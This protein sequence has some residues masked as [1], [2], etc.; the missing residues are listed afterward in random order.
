MRIFD[1]IIV[2]FWLIFL[3]YWLISSIG[4]KSNQQG[5][6]TSWLREAGVRLAIA[7]TIIL[8]V[9]SPLRR[10]MTSINNSTID[11]IGVS[12]CGVGIACAIWARV[13][14][15][16]NWGMPATLKME[17]ELVSNGPYALV[18]HPIYAGI[19]MAIVGTALV[20]GMSGFVV[21]VVLCT[22]FL[23][24]ATK[25]EKF[26][27]KEFPGRYADYKHR[28]KMLIPFVL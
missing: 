22:Y 6:G 15:G 24:S 9:K 20:A 26:M 3:V 5:T 16:R 28:T 11:S 13:Y 14:L 7:I 23:H 1:T 10:Y 18:R 21:F 8:L 27:T 17:P 2:V 4:V 12:F 25:E 19:L